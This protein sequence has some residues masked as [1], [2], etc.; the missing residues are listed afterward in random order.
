MQ[1]IIGCNIF[2][3]AYSIATVKTKLNKKNQTNTNNQNDF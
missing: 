2:H 1:V 3:L